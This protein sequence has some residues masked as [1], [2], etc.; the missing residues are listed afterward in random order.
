MSDAVSDAG[1]DAVS[2]AGGDAVSDAGGDGSATPAIA[3]RN[4]TKS[5]GGVR[6]LDSIDV[7]FERGTITSLV[8]PNGVG[9]T[10]LLCSLAGGLVP[11]RG[12]VEID[13]TPHN[14]AARIAFAPQNALSLP[15]L[16]GRET[17][18]FY[19][20]LHPRSTERWRDLV[21]TFEIAG[22][23]DDLVRNYSGGMRRLLE[24]TVALSIDAPVVLLDEPSASLD[25]SM[26]RTLQEVLRRRIAD[27][28]TVVLTSHTPL[29]AE[30]ADRLVFMTRNGITADGPPD[31]LRSSL[32]PVVART[33][34]T[35]SQTELP[36]VLADRWLRHGDRLRGF[37]PASS[38]VDESDA[39]ER[40]DPTYHDLFEYHASIEP[41]LGGDCA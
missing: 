25:M 9:K 17:I 40:V 21:E 2:D 30:L 8:G 34:G 38:I 5:L 23:L 15:G 11:D 32:P 28:S 3:A 26:V 1:G 29:D 35:R 22:R 37:L 7:R 27:G 19:T 31:E 41:A 16:T 6:L 10:V 39:I 36:S 12:T 33:T 20:S 24:L 14:R 4:L 18:D 13:G